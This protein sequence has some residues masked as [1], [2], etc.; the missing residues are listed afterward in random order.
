M[1]RAYGTGGLVLA[2]GLGL[3]SA[4]QAQSM[5]I[6]AIT[7]DVGQ[8]VCAPFIESRDMAAAISA[9]EALG[10]RVIDIE[11]DNQ[12][13]EQNPPPSAVRMERRHGG[14]I[15]LSRADTFSFCAIGMA[16]GGVATIAETAEPFLR[17]LGMAP[18]LDER[19]GTNAISVWR[20]GNRQAVIARSPHHRPGSELVISVATPR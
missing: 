17:D 7:R 13:G 11:P 19:E 15:T 3:S 12:A 5:N 6:R 1:R 2:A 14:R 8:G 20:G 10:Y 4:V 9:G 16:E 18:A